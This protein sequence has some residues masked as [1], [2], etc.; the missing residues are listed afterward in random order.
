MPA[1]VDRHVSCI[2]DVAP[3][4][5]RVGSTDKQVFILCQLLAGSQLSC[6]AAPDG[7]TI[8]LTLTFVA[9]PEA[10]AEASDGPPTSPPMG[11]LPSF[12]P[13]SPA[14]AEVAI[15]EVD[16]AGP[17]R[18]TIELPAHLAVD[19]DSRYQVYDRTDAVA[20]ITFDLLTA[21]SAATAPSEERPAHQTSQELELER[22][23]NQRKLSRSD[24]S[25][26]SVAIFGGER[27][28]SLGVSSVR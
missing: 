10:E 9:P 6:L 3:C 16:F 28:L 13:K 24:S 12:S 1:L 26:P 7:R 4:A 20:T 23:G 11:G 19:P 5:V 2:T 15:G 18:R 25:I 27:W 21:L 17:I 22:V 14:P 8:T